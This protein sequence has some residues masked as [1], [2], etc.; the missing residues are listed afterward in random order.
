MHRLE[1]ASLNEREARGV[2]RLRRAALLCVA[3]IL[4]SG[5]FWAVGLARIQHRYE[6]PVPDWL[7]YLLAPLGFITIAWG[8]VT[9]FL[10]CPRCSAPFVAFQL[11]RLHVSPGTKCFH[12]GLP[13]LPSPAA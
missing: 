2:R 8:A 3:L 9:A 6:D 13:L 11:V 12:C 5:V 10:P 7:W 4:S 1:S